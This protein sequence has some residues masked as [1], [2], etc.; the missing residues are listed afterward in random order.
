MLFFQGAMNVYLQQESLEH[1]S[2]SLLANVGVV[3]MNT[4]DVGWK[5]MLVQWLE[6][7]S[8][9]DRDLLSSLCNSYIEKVLMFVTECTQPPMFGQKKTTGQLTYKRVVQHTPENM[10]HTFCNLLEVGH[11]LTDSACQFT[12]A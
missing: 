8:E 7:R 3:C 10:V 12:Q 11:T 4:S 6:H 2:P 9:A 5:L 1:L